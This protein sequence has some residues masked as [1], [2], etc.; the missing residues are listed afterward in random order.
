MLNGVVSGRPMFANVDI[1]LSSGQ[2][3]V[4]DGKTLLWMD[5]WSPHFNLTYFTL[6]SS[7]FIS[8]PYIIYC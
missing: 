6:P 5:G 4:A 8:Y 3:V 2:R 1:D 7:H